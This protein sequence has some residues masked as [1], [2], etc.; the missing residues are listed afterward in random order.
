[1]SAFDLDEDWSVRCGPT[2]ETKPVGL[3]RKLRG[4]FI[5]LL[6]LLVLVIASCVVLGTFLALR[7]LTRSHPSSNDTSMP[8]ARGGVN[9][10]HTNTP[11]DGSAAPTNITKFIEIVREKIVYVDRELVKNTTTDPS[12]CLSLSCLTDARQLLS[13]MNVSANIC[14]QFYDFTVGEMEVLPQS[15][16]VYRRI[17]YDNQL[18]RSR[19]LLERGT[20][21]IDSSAPAWRRKFQDY[22]TSCVT[23]GETVEVGVRAIRQ[24]I[25]QLGGWSKS[26]HNIGQ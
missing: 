26:V 25:Y 8:M 22:Y 24:K 3:S 1:M 10:S 19:R 11:T 4:T 7:L 23:R 13:G 14:D 2:V 15:G 21:T 16:G 9:F 17:N 18:E 20:S 12:K 6:V 5:C